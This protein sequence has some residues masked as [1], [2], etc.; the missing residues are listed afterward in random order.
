[1]E[2]SET[3]KEFLWELDKHDQLIL[4]CAFGRITFF[5]FLD[6]YNDFYAW[7]PL[8]SHESNAEEQGLLVKYQDR[9]IPHRELFHQLSNICSDEDSHKEAYIQAGRFGSDEGLRRLKEISK[10][11]LELKERVVS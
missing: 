5:E 3:E 10:K 4:D 6:K 8:D 11:Y 2:M 1:M 7:Y 9:I